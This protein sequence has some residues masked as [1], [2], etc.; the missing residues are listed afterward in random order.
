MI[1]AQGIDKDRLLEDI[2]YL[3]SPKLEGRAPLTEGS[4]L[5]QEYI[6][7]RFKEFGLVSQYKEFVQPFSLKERFPD[8][9]N[10]FGT[11]VVGF[12]PGSASDKI[13]LVLAHYD[14]LGKRG[15]DLYLG[16]D[17]NA[18]GVGALLS[19]AG[20]FARERPAHSMIF[21][22]V[23]AEEIGL[24]GSKALVN[25]FPFPLEQIALVVNMDMISRSSTNRL[26]AV[27]SRY[28]PQFRPPLLV[29]KSRSSIELVLGNEGEE[30]GQNWTNSSDHAP[31]HRQGVPFVYFGVDDHE[32]YHKPTDTFENIDPDFYHQA[33]LLIL[34]FIK[35]VDGTAVP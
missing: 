29:V 12:A 20:Y 21:A 8:K 6:V 27:G 33:T 13:I 24:L 7:G 26:Y 19:L 22:A 9:R 31:F 11:N 25:D 10:P 30:G 4:R 14:H 2:K 17:D 34:D 18:S 32:D 23:D 15:E 5:A 28:Y 35:E 1:S 3:A 16:A